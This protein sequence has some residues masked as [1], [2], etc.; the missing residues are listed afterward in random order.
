MQGRPLCD[1]VN[2]PLRYEL[3]AT[4]LGGMRILDHLEQS[5][6]DTV[7]VRPQLG[8]ADGPWFAWRLLTWKSAS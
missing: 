1:A 2:G 3:R 4:W 7:L 6:F 5:R 8:V